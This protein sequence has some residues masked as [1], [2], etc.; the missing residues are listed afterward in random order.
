MARSKPNRPKDCPF[1]SKGG[2]KLSFALQ[3]FECSVQDQVVGDLGSH[4][5]GFLDCLLQNGALKAYAVDTAYGTLAWKLR[6]DPRVIVH[7]RTNALHWKAPEPLSIISIDV[8]WTPQKYIIPQACQSLSKEGTI[9]S[10]LKPQYEKKNEKKKKW[11]LSQEEVE[12]IISKTISLHKERFA[13]VH[14][15]HSPYKGS[16]GNTE[17][18]FCLREPIEVN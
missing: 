11:V 12:E 4:M 14:Y 2:L 15:V 10:L 5:G 8:G 17:V 7:E 6:Q 9:L 16:G 18:W 13:Q 3:H 1:A